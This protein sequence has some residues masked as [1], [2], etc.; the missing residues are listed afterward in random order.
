M[1]QNYLLRVQGGPKKSYIFNPPPYVYTGGAHLAAVGRRGGVDGQ[2]EVVGRLAE[3]VLER[4]VVARVRVGGE[5]QRERGAD[6]RRLGHRQPERRAGQEE[7]SVVVDVDDR[8]LRSASTAV[9]AVAERPA[10]RSSSAEI[11][12][13]SK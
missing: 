12:P 13:R 10:R 7:R 8:H 4:A 9:G 2:P 11:F 5:R 3:P 1:E 6:R